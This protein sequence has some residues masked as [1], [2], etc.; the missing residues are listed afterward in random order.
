MHTVERAIRRLERRAFL[1]VFLGELVRW[2][3]AIGFVLGAVVLL[4]RVVLHVDASHTAPLFLLALVA[5]GI[6]WWRARAKRMSR[7]SAAA[8]Q[9]VRAGASGLLLTGMEVPDERWSA[10][11][12]RTLQ[13]SRTLPRIRTGGESYALGVAVLFA[14]AAWWVHVPEPAPGPSF[15]LFEGAIERLATKLLTL[16]E[17][18]GLFD[19]TAQDLTNRL[20]RLRE[21]LEDATPESAFEA[22]DRLEEQFGAL[23]KRVQEDVLEAEGGILAAAREAMLNPESAQEML[24]RTLDKLHESGLDKNL[25]STIESLSSLIERHDLE[26]PEDLELPGGFRLPAGLEMTG[27]EILEVAQD[28]SGLLGKKLGALEDAGLLDPGALETALR[29]T[30]DDLQFDEH[31]CDES[32]REGGT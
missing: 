26:L 27:P 5:P 19:E 18:V 21:G 1:A 14:A 6:A 22:I 7:G 32:C 28:L 24:E 4:L 15:A 17:D 3:A 23:A 11:V 8:W 9:D 25:L 2:G 10:E 20:E 16:E 31:E 29:E 13:R 30:F 12:E